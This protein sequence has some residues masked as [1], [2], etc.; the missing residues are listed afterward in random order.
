MPKEFLTNAVA[1]S[2]SPAYAAVPLAKCGKVTYNLP[3][4]VVFL[5]G[6]TRFP[7]TIMPTA[8]EYMNILDNSIK[9]QSNK[10]I[11]FKL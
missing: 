10:E 6:T 5:P 3:M 2:S 7:S 8:M 4:M 11:Y 9:H 1:M